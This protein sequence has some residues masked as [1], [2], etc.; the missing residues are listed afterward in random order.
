M[1]HETGAAILKVETARG[2]TNPVT[3]SGR[4]RF[5][6][7]VSTSAGSDAIEELELNAMS[8]GGSAAR[9]KRRIGI[10]RHDGDDGIEQ[11]RD[12][13]VGD[14]VDDD[15]EADGAGERGSRVHRLRQHEREDAE[16]RGQDD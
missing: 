5:A 13:E 7:A 11:E 3:L 15:V 6:S 12:G 1:V 4:P 8:C 16:R 10:L 14:G 2:R 9:A